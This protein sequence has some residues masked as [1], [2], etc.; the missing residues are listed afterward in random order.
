MHGLSVFKYALLVLALQAEQD[1]VPAKETNSS[2]AADTVTRLREEADQLKKGHVS[3]FF[4]AL[5]EAIEAGDRQAVSAQLPPMLKNDGEAIGNALRAP[6]LVQHA[7][8]AARA[9][10]EFYLKH[11]LAPGTKPPNLE[12]WK[13]LKS[14]VV[15]HAEAIVLEGVLRPNEVR[16]WKAQASKPLAPQL[17]GADSIIPIDYPDGQIPAATAY[18]REAFYNVI[19]QWQVLERRSSELFA[20]LLGYPPIVPVSAARPPELNQKFSGLAPDQVRVLEDVDLLARNVRRYWLVRDV[21][22]PPGARDDDD[23]NEV[24]KLPPTRAMEVRL[25]DAG[26]RVRASIVAHV[27]EMALETVL[28]PE[29]LEKAKIELWRQRGVHALLDPEI[30]ARLHL[31][32]AQRNELAV[33]IANRLEVYHRVVRKVVLIPYATAPANEILRLERQHKEEI[34]QNV[35]RLDQPIWECLKPSQLRSLAGLLDKPVAG[36]EGIQTPMN[37]S[38]GPTGI[39]TPMN[40]SVGPT[41]QGF[42]H[43][44]SDTHEPVGRTNGPARLLSEPE[45]V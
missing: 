2:A 45:A 31:S 21:E 10:L 41:G 26:L 38:V 19:Y 22:P 25:S 3:H 6:A 14:K 15:A 28:R 18:T 24:R 1:D 16:R 36:I 27:E 35:A 9:V 13:R 34:A 42:R 32:R 11:A 5:I 12:E 30:A 7:D 20:I 8:R 39:Q 37:P 23:S 44:D 29:Q 33:A 4:D 17:S 40:P 43:R